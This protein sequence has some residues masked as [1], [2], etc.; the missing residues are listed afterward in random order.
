M[1]LSHLKLTWG[2]SSLSI[3]TLEFIHLNHDGVCVCSHCW[4]CS[5]LMTVRRPRTALC[6]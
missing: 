2:Q 5:W 3:M 6:R 4:R 1:K